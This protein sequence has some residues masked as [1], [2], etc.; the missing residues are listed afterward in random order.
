MSEYL[1]TT[2]EKLVC[3]IDVD[4]NFDKPKEIFP[5]PDSFTALAR[6]ILERMVE[7]RTQVLQNKIIDMDRKLNM[8]LVNK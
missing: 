8:L 6:E 3:E 2:R 4:T 5:Q 1:D 7:Q